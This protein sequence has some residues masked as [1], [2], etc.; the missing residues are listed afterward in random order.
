MCEFSALSSA[1]SGTDFRRRA[2]LVKESLQMPY[3]AFA[4]SPTMVIDPD[5][6]IGL[7]AAAGLIAGGAC[8]LDMAA[9]WVWVHAFML[10]A[11]YDAE[12]I[13]PDGSRHANQGSQADALTHC[14][15]SC[16]VAQYPGPCFSALRGASYLNNREDQRLPPDA[17]DIANNT[18]GA[19]LGRAESRPCVD[20]C[21]EALQRGE[22]FTFDQSGSIPLRP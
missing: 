7:I 19:F 5:G 8:L 21:L 16:R 13:A 14:I 11:R 10:P 6:R 17:M 4:N 12:R 20:Q 15:F 1:I 3:L 22:L 9:C 2:E 18:Q